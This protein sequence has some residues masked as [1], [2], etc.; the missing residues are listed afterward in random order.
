MNVGTTY[1][2]NWQR[3]NKVLNIQW[4]KIKLAYKYKS[5][6]VTLFVTYIDKCESAFVFELFVKIRK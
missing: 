1:V 3:I 4:Y 2:F 5:M 6:W